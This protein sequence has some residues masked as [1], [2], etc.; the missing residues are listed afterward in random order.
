MPN[1]VTDF[2]DNMS[3]PFVAISSPDSYEV[4]DGY[5]K[6]FLQK[7][8]GVVTTAG[9]V[10]NKLGNGATLNSTFTLL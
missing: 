9:R 7:P 10:N 3:A 5:L 2:A 8:P 6:L 4:E 1:S